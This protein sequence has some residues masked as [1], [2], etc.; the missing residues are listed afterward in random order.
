VAYDRELAD[1]VRAAL[2]G[3]P[4]VREVRMFGG[5]SFLVND[6]LAISADSHGDLMVR[7]DAAR[8]DDLLATTGATQA[9]M[10]GK[11]MSR[12]WLVVAAARVAGDAD[13]ARWIALALDHNDT[14]THGTGRR[15]DPS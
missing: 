11:A 10:K 15:A 2:A 14:V 6:K 4:F 1:R 13:L 12:G 7:C 5:L 9:E 3:R 8:V